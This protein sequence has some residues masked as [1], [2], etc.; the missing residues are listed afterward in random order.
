MQTIQEQD[1]I[2]D[3]EQ[4]KQLISQVDNSGISA[5]NAG[6]LLMIVKNKKEYVPRYKTFENYTKTEIDISPQTANNYIIIRSNF[7]KEEIGNIMLVSH[8]RVI[9]E[10]END[11]LRKLVLKEIR[12][13][14]SQETEGS[15]GYKPTVSDIVGIVTMIVDSEEYDLTEENIEEIININIEKGKEEAK[16]R[17]RNRARQKALNGKDPFGDP[18]TSEY[19]KDVSALLENEP[20]NE[21]GVVGL[22]C[23]MFQSLR[24]TQFEWKEEMITFVAIKYIQTAFPDANIRCKT[25]GKKKK[26]FE[27]DVEFEFESYNYIRHGHLNSTKNCDLIICWQDNARS[28]ERLKNNPSVKKLPPILSLKNCFDTGEIELLV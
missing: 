10:I 23:I 5:W 15:E 19:F 17:K 20:I 22:F 13:K 6:D 28:D 8:L 3:T 12:E 11:K 18:F 21:M 7:T 4:L 16:K 27:L 14:E 26:N 2:K 25:T 1:L 24:G 9:A